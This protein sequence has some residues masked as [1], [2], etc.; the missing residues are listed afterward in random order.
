M[1][2]R[3]F[4]NS[5]G[6]KWQEA[7]NM[8]FNDLPSHASSL[9]VIRNAAQAQLVLQGW[10]G[11]TASNPWQSTSAGGPSGFWLGYRQIL[12]NGQANMC[13]ATWYLAQV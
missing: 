7:V 4:Y 9:A 13:V 10:C 12:V 2:Y 6:F 3:T 5:A 1:C 11:G 8:C